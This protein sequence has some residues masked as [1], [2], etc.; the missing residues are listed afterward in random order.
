M[1]VPLLARVHLGTVAVLSVLTI[2]ACLLIAG[3]P[4]GM[5]A[6]F[7]QAL[8]RSL[9]T[10]AAQQADLTVAVASDSREEDLHER[11]QFAARDREWRDLL[12]PGLRPLITPAGTGSSHMSAKTTLTP[13]TGT[14]GTKYVN[15]GWLS[16]AGQRVTWVQGRPPG[17]PGTTRYDGE[18]IPVFEVGVVTQALREMDLRVGDT[19]TLG[20]ND[21]VA[22]KIVGA[23]EAKDPG[24]RYWDHNLDILRVTKIQPPG[25]LDFEK[26]ITSLMSDDGLT[27]LSGE[28]R[29]LAYHWVLPVDATAANALDVPGL[30]AAIADFDRL[31]GIQSTG[32]ASPYRLITGLPKLL[33]DFRAALATAETVMY[34]VLGGL[35]AVALG[36][37]VL[38][39]QLLA[40]RMEHPLTLA[41]ARGGSLR[42]VAG[43]GA[44]L[45]GLAVAPAALAGYALSYLVPG[46]VLP[47]VH[48][49]PVLVILVTVG[50]AATRLAVTYRTPLHERRDD[51]ATARPSARRIT[52]EVLVVV[53]ALA[54]AYLLRARGL[55]DSAGQD[56]FL[57][58]VPIALTLAAAL[59]T[60]RCYPF[61]LRLLVRL[62]ARGRAAVPF[63]GLTRA[64]RARSASVLPVLILLPALGVSVFAAVISDGI[65]GTQ[66]RASWQQVGA[67]IKMTSNIEIP[68][69]AVERVRGTAGVEQ[70]VPAQTAR[71]QVGYGAERAEAIAVD[72]AQWRRLMG[73]APFDLPDLPDG[74]L[75]SPEL[76]GRGTF[77]IGWQSRLKLATRGV[78]ESVPGFYT[79]G[80]FLVV[81]IDVLTRPAVNTLL[82]KGDAS[83]E[84]LERLVPSATV[85]SQ[86]GTLR[87]IQDDPL[88]STV[89]WTMVVVTVALAAYALVAVVLALVI[90]AADRARAV[91][92]LR[93]LG[94]SERQAQ[95]LTVLE[96]LPM[97]LVTALVGLG[98]GLGLPAALGPGVDLSSYAGDLPVGDYSLDLFLPS[99]LAAGLAAVAVLGAYAHTAVSR[100][101]RL[102]AVLRVGDLT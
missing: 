19:K 66:T 49:G 92:F 54:G 7:D 46:P 14:S 97:I 74:A 79:S 90:G 12:P 78:I 24:D 98:L 99:A 34:L 101:R 33:G 25:S 28:G 13:I 15:L 27:A 58:L 6:S 86:E 20:E 38:G 94:L 9:S 45:T 4:R 82:I 77:E 55:D 68:A 11:D 35:L 73:E 36:V 5:Q 50:Y 48:A 32:T 56:P 72:V 40:D 2:S 37:L 47:I 60:L 31:I 30:T 23:F 85:V 1:R 100:R 64:A 61:P 10:A 71:V 102:G 42:Q 69:E 84:E 89:R 75:V 21:Y 80:K 59:I 96:I 52:L 67:P 62:T 83:V 26:H 16:D 81:P 29:H 17:R 76:R 70:V 43:T 3:L 8:R 88:T 91:S 51:V 93:T 95:R 39:V 22:V 57:L 63:L 41:R 53:L 18:T 87:A 65:A 44:A